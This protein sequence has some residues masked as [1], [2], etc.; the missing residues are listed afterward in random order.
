MKILN[1]KMAKSFKQNLSVFVDGKPI[2][3]NSGNKPTKIE[4]QNNFVTLRILK[5]NT[6]NGK[7]WFLLNIFYYLI[8]IFGL[9]NRTYDKKFYVFDCEYKINLQQD[10]TDF[11]VMYDFGKDCDRKILVKT[12]SEYQKNREICYVDQLA[13]KRNKKMRFA[14]I[15]ILV[16]AV[17][18]IVTSIIL[19]N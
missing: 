17:A 11:E 4:T 14:K 1:L 8:S 12:T 16:I 5:L 6:F 2:Q 9:L 19:S 13:K 18:I 7:H 3:I 15:A 10:I